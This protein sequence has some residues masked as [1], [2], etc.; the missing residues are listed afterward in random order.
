MPHGC[1]CSANSSGLRPS[2]RAS[3]RD[4]HRD[5]QGASHPSP[6]ADATNHPHAGAEKTHFEPYPVE[7]DGQS[8]SR[9]LMQSYYII[10]ARGCIDSQNGSDLRERIISILV[11]HPRDI[12][13]DC[14]DVV[15]MDSSGF[16]CL[17]SALKRVRELDME[18]GLCRINS[19]LRSV[20]ELAGV[21]QIYPIFP[22]IEDFIAHVS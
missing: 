14:R 22:A 7:L 8:K 9:V 19:Q 1:R 18:L 3:G 2:L 6:W 10:P 20:L 4:S 13:I 17:V 16:G 15:F 21:A 12:L 11:E 5:Q